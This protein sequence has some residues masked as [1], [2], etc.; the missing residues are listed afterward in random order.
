MA[1]LIDADA[2]KK[3]LEEDIN[4]IGVKTDDFVE[5]YDLGIKVAIELLDNAPTV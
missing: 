4:W 3:A 1:R 5:G 2:L